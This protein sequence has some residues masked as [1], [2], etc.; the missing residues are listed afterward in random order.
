M[1][2][3]GGGKRLAVECD[4]DRW[5]TLDNLDED[6]ARQ[7]VLERLGWTFV[8]IRGS[9]F[10]RDPEQTM[11]TVYDKLEKMGIPPEGMLE[12]KTGIE[13]GEQ[14]TELVNR[15]KRRAA[16]LRREWEESDRSEGTIKVAK[17][18]KWKNN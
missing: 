6:M 8:R 18:N 2:V 15:I 7:A 1:V 13:S 3:E 12:E 4:G 10:Y 16:E 14:D 17:K 11:R 9:A 5:H